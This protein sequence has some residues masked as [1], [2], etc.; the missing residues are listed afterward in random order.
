M[1]TI[2]SLLARACLRFYPRS[3]RDR[4]ADEVL[5]LV[6]EADAGIGDVVDLA[7]GCLN[8]R[9]DENA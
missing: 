2:R 3:W 5:L 7:L 9:A 1:R 8:R 4:Y 6:E